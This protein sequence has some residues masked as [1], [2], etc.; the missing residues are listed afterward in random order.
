MTSSCAKRCSSVSAV[1]AIFALGVLIAVVWVQFGQSVSRHRLHSVNVTRL[2][3]EQRKA[4]G[5]T[6]ERKGKGMNCR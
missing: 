3:G 1:A 2:V 5:V 6:A 4:D